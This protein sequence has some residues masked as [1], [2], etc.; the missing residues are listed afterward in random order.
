MSDEP[1]TPL[2]NITIR[3][4]NKKMYEWEQSWSE[5]LV[6]PDQYQDQGTLQLIS[7]QPHSHTATA[8]QRTASHWSIVRE[9]WKISSN[10]ETLGRIITCHCIVSWLG[11]ELGQQKMFAR[12]Q[13]T[14]IIK[15]IGSVCHELITTDIPSIPSI[16]YWLH[17]NILLLSVLHFFDK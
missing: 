15:I 5:C 6:Y 2:E 16:P 10:R 1:P 17:P 8:E 7:I 11:T 13:T 4:S 14:E 3:I 12:L 9:N